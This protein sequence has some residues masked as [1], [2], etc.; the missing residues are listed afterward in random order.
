[1]AVISNPRKNFQFQV[2]I[3][4]INTF[5][6]QE[7]KLPEI[8][9]EPVEHG[10]TNYTIKTG[11]KVKY[12]TLNL[13]K[14]VE[15]SGLDQKIWT[16]VKLIQNTAVGGGLLPSLYKEVIRIDQ[17]HANG[18]TVVQT[19]VY[20]GCWPTKINGIDFSRTKSENTIED[21]DF[22]VDRLLS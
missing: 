22:S 15:M 9:I 8:E 20:E 6:C 18:I 14:I 19:W 11:G 2:Y 7:V 21:I 4:G 17:L 10:E 1:M 13:K 3:N 16:W 12:G 5:A